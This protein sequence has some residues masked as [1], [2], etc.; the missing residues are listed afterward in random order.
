MT[1][2]AFTFPLKYLKKL[3]LASS[4]SLE[5]LTPTSDAYSEPVYVPE[6]QEQ[7][8]LWRK[9]NTQPPSRK[10]HAVGQFFK[11]RGIL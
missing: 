4:A 9:V 1:S 8:P 5:Y 2:S 3:L 6:V 11:R 7:L 10:K